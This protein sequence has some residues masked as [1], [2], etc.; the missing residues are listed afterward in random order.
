MS[1]HSAPGVS[2]FPLPLLQEP[3]H[4][5][6]SRSRRGTQRRRRKELVVA[7][8]NK[9]LTCL[10]NLFFSFGSQSQVS[11]SLLSHRLQARVRACA[12]EFVGRL[13]APPVSS[14]DGSLS[15]LQSNLELSYIIRN[16][17]IPLVADRVSLPA[18]AGTVDMLALLPPEL[19]AIYSD[20][21]KLLKPLLQRDKMPRPCHRVSPSEY[22]RLVVRLYAMGMVTF[23]RV[24]EVVNGIF[25][26]PKDGNLIRLILDAR[27]ANCVFGDP[28]KVELPT[29]D[30]VA[31][32]MTDGKPFF[33]LKLDQDNYYHR[34]K[35]P[36]WM[37]PFFAIAKIRAGDLGRR[38]CRRF[39]FGPDEW[40]YPC[41]VTMPMGWSHAV[42]VGQTMHLNFM[43]TRTSFRPE[44]RIT[45]ANDCR[46]DRPR[47]GVYID[48]VFAFGDDRDQM[49]RDKE[50]YKVESIKVGL[51]VKPSKEF[52]PTLE[53]LDVIGLELDSVKHT[54]RLASGKLRFLVGVTEHVLHRGVCTGH[55]MEV[56]VGH[57]IWAALVRRPVF[58]VLSAVYTFIQRA[59][60]RSFELWPSVRREL[61]C[62]VGLAPLLF[63]A[64][65]A[66]WWH[67]VVAVDASDWGLGVVAASSLAEDLV[68]LA[69][70]AGKIPSGSDEV[71]AVADF[72]ADRR[73]ATIV[74]SPWLFPELAAAE[75]I[76][77]REARAF[78]TGLRWVL[79]HPSS[80]GRRVVILS[81]SSNVVG[82][83]SKG[84]SSSFQLLRCLRHIS[85]LLL[86][87]GLYVSVIWVPTESNPA[88]E[89]SRRPRSD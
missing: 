86:A 62:L 80:L 33:K 63:A 58:A 72:V 14:C 10:N 67:K 17:A 78:T 27:P 36:E 38:F 13:E 73:W 21:S 9:C 3:T 31:R 88:D 42:F 49:V 30:L 71:P 25:G 34:I 12:D 89:P 8:T 40:V 48:D 11:S 2:P 70:D 35:V 24:V 77:V 59:E 29:P 61:R 76:G 26:V 50:E 15:Q 53:P 16:H 37:I 74:G 65:D 4:S 22:L 83:V 66:S 18:E 56:L 39:G 64:L 52:G 7:V 84:R 19:A 69:R 44:D 28:P 82:A 6:P 60:W 41:F 55:D 23:R 45:K 81:D 1:G 87:G 51:F 5:A 75:H 57:W 32:M 46:L 43:D 54:F 47:H 85:A 79:S 20:P 68:S